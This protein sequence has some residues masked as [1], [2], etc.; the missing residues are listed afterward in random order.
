MEPGKDS[1][2]KHISNQFNIEL[3]QIR[4]QML[5][6][7]GIVERQVSD[8][9]EALMNG[10]IELAE[11]ARQSDKTANQMEIDIDQQCTKIIALR[12]PAASDL[13]LIISISRAAS[14]LE[15]IGDESGRISKHAIEIANSG[16]NARFG[17]QEVR[18]IGM[19][20]TE[21]V[22]DVLNAFSRGDLEMAYKVAKRDRE[23]DQEYRSATRSLVTYMME[24]PR[25]ISVILNVMW[26][27][28]S[29]E[30]IGDHARSIAIHLIYQVSGEDVR[31]KSLREIKEA[32]HDAS[33]EDDLDNYQSE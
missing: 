4:T 2:S 14:D 31:H 20:V 23:V 30:R 11:Q 24:D 26:I 29:L 22:R 27:L 8:S 32:V 15:R 17:Y 13:R 5:S 21:M 19:I 10:D 3:E 18:H 7:G 9:I 16:I 12:Q 33:P 25:S 1:F 28:R 6:M